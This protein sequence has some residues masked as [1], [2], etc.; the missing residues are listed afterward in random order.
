MPW[1]RTSKAPK[2]TMA[3]LGEAG[4]LAQEVTDELVKEGVQSFADSFDKLLAVVAQRRRVLLDGEKCPVGDQA[5]A[6]RK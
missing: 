2:A 1:S 4:H 5:R 3:A 6:R